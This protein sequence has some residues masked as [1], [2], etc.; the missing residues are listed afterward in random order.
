MGCASSY[1]STS[2][3]LNL[4]VDRSRDKEK[5]RWS[6]LGLDSVFG[7]FALGG[8]PVGGHFTGLTLQLQS[9]IPMVL[10]KPVLDC[11]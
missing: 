9:P 4:S 8:R 11:C 7:V 5:E 2:L 6:K 10:I 3:A 1:M